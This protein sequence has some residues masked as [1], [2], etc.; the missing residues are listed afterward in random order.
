MFNFVWNF[1][2]EGFEECKTVENNDVQDYVGNIRV[3]NLC[4]DIVQLDDEDKPLWIDCYVGGVDSGYGYGKDDYPYDYV[5]EVG[6]SF[7]LDEYKNFTYEQ[8][9]EIVEKE[10]TD[11][12]N[13]TPQYTAD[14]GEIVNLIDKANEELKNW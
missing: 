9:V 4:F 11:S 14:N 2:K 5:S 1:S 10:L 7:D 8:F 12:I 6:A 3:G 13:N